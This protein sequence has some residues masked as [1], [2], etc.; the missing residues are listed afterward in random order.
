MI[1]GI[2]FDKDGTLIEF[3]STMHHIYTTIFKGLEN[4]YHVPEVLLQQLKKTLG[5]LPDHLESD[6][7]LQISTNPQIVEALLETARGYASKT[8]W[9]MPFTQADLLTLIEEYSSSEEIPYTALPGVVETLD[10]LKKNGY[11]IGLATAD[12]YSSTI[13]GLKKVGILDY[14]DYLGTDSDEGRP[15]PDTYLADRFCTQCRVA[16]NELLIVGD[17]KKDMLFAKN[18][19]ADFL[20]VEAPCNETPIFQGTGFKSIYSMNELVALYQF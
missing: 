19:G 13:V 6:S 16:P 5:H 4:R 20:G 17:S 11:K 9:H 14:F 2:L 12:T 8:Q 18:V 10:Y 3:H 1:K 15:K 7:L